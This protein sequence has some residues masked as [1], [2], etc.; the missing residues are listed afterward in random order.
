[1]SHFHKPTPRMNPCLLLGNLEQTPLIEGARNGVAHRRREEAWRLPVRHLEAVL[2]GCMRHYRRQA[3]APLS[4]GH[5]PK[6]LHRAVHHQVGGPHGRRQRR[7]L[8]GC[9]GHRIRQRC[10]HAVQLIVH[11]KPNL[12]RKSLLTGHKFLCARTTSV[13]DVV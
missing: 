3:P 8:P 10:H 9:S 1:V 5:S 2:R 11:L 7:R 13:A 6:R 4:L 12:P